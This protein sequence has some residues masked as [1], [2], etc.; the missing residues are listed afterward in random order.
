MSGAADR[1][2]RLARIPARE[3]LVRLLLFGL[4][5]LSA[6]LSGLIP[7]LEGGKQRPP[8]R[9]ANR[10]ADNCGACPEPRKISSDLQDKS[11]H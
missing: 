5:S 6:S 10:R 2:K 3:T 9:T 8:D 4:S 1:G 7:P 11:I